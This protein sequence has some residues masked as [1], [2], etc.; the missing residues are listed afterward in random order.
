[1][2]MQRKGN[3]DYLG[4]WGFQTLGGAGGQTVFNALTTGTHGGDIKFPPI[5][6]SVVALHLV[7]DGG[8]HYWIEPGTPTDHTHKLQLT[9]DKKL[10]A[11]YGNDRYLGAAINWADNLD[12]S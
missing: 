2:Y 11:L 8:K 4:P 12:N 7:A 5:A 9:D 1:M 10:K 3:S 6:D